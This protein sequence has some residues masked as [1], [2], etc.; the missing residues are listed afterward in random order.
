[1][2][3][4]TKLVV[5]SALAGMALAAPTPRQPAKRG[6]T[7]N[8]KIAKPYQAPAV[9]LRK[10]YQKY[11]VAVPED[12]AKAASGDGSVAATPE[13]GDVEYLSPVEIG[14]QTVNLDFDT[15]SA[16]LYVVSRAELT[17][18]TLTGIVGSSLPSCRDRSNPATSCMTR[19]SRTRRNN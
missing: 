8:Q 4:I 14:G 18:P 10:V 15:G 11:N 16:D 6:F 19:P 1:M 5:A 3:S 2:P 12:V 17:I 9:Q 7:V 13:Q